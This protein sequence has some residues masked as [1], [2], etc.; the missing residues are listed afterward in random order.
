MLALKLAITAA[1][2]IFL[3]L[4]EKLQLTQ[5]RILP[6]G[7]FWIPVAGF[8]VLLLMAT[9]QIRFW[10]L[11]RSAGVNVRAW[12][13]VRAGAIS[14]FL[15]ACLLGG[16]GFLSGDAIRIGYLMRE[17]DN[18]SAIVGAALLDRIMGLLGLLT[19]AAFGLVIGHRAGLHEAELGFL[20]AIVYSLVIAGLATAV[21]LLA[22]RRW[23]WPPQLKSFL[24]NCG[25]KSGV[26]A[27]AISTG[28]ALSL[29]R[30]DT[31]TKVSAYAA[32]I[33]GHCLAVLAIFALG[34]GIAIDAIP[35]I[36]HVVFAAPIAFLT[37]IL[38]LPGNGI[39]VG[40]VAFDSALRL[41]PD[42]AGAGMV[43]GA[44]LYLSYRILTT[45][46]ALIGLPLFLRSR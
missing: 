15:N 2:I 1:A 29:Y 28:S 12:R 11:L 19:L 13:V 4:T 8:L 14:W 46:M 40:E 32:A 25:G 21:A 31:L 20:P 27:F 43:G 34:H 37:T 36:G 30:G 3:Y 16:L 45:V 24:E 35:S 6:A 22:M 38:P 23:G 41:M 44:A 9:A 33:M 39:G 26:V 18:L 7:Q 17:S 5:L 10:L 42:T